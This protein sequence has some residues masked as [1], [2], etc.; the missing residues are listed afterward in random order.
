MH[1]SIEGAVISGIQVVDRIAKKIKL[2][3]EAYLE[4]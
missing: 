1:G 4:H 3:R 2:N